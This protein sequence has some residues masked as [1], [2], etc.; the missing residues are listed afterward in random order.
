MICKGAV[1]EV[2]A[3]CKYC[4]IDGRRRRL[5][6]IRMEAALAKARELNED[7]LRVLA[8]A[9]KDI[10]RG[11]RSYCVDDERDLTLLGFTAFLDPPKSDAR[12]ALRQLERSGV[13]VKILTG[14]NEVVTRKICREVGLDAERVALAMRSRRWTTRRSPISR[15]A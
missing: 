7:G 3:A 1:E 4:E 13:A 14:D 6:A 2:L 11:K 12:E 5:D 9:R 10:A 8:V 15:R